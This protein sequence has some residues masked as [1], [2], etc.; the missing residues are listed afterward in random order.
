MEKFSANVNIS[1]TT[2][3]LLFLATKGYNPRMSFNLMD[4]SA[5]LTR[6]KIANST[7]RLI[8]NHMEE[9]WDFMQEKIIKLQPKQIIAANCHCKKPPVYKVGDKV[10]LLTRNIRTERSSKKL[11]D[12]NICPFKI[13]K[14][15]ELLYQLELPHTMKIHDVFH[16]NLL[17]KA[18]NN[19]LS[20]QR[21][22]PS[23]S[24]VMNNKEKWEV[25]DIL[26]AKHGKG[27]KKM[28][29]WVK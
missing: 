11:D 29:F 3:V 24:T 4:L 25:N 17:W 15:I 2:K 5:N 27:G 28:L 18:A 14:L 20:G 6:E 22:S 8:A 23:L 19:H 9:V 26:D 13:K 7:A 21:N 10:F 12:K 1:A 16:A